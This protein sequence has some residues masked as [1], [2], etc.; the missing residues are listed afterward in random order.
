MEG[1]RITVAQLKEVLKQL[2]LTPR[3]NKQELLKKLYDHDPTG[4]WKRWIGR[5]SMEEVSAEV[6]EA[7]VRQEYGEDEVEERRRQVMLQDLPRQM[8]REEDPTLHDRELE[9]LRRERDIMRRELEILR[10]ERDIERANDDSTNLERQSDSV[11]V[12]T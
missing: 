12:A 9:I 2:G 7:D 10:R 1:E 3:G 5:I 8:T 11:R 6:D 4:A